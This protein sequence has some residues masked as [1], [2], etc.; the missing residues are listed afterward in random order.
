MVKQEV[1]EEKNRNSQNNEIGL[2]CVCLILNYQNTDSLIVHFAYLFLLCK[3]LS[4]CLFYCSVSLDFETMKN[5]PIARF[6][7]E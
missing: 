3:H 5:K 7:I 4:I 1:A 2:Q 6:I